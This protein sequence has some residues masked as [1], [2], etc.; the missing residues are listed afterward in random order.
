MAHGPARWAV[1]IGILVAGLAGSARADEESPP[2]GRG[3]GER[4]ASFELTDV[5]S[6]QSRD[7]ARD[8]GSK[9]TVLVFLGTDCPVGNLYL[10]R[11]NEL[12]ATYASKGV[13]LWGINANASE[14]AATVADHARKFHLSFPVL[15]DSDGHVA[16][17]LQALRT[18]EAL[19]IGADGV[20]HY[21]GAIDDQYQVGLRKDSEQTRHHLALA[22][23]AVIDG[24][25]PDTT[26]TTVDGCPIERPKDQANGRKPLD[27]VRPPSA[28]IV[29]AY[30]QIEGKD[31]PDVGDVTYARDVAP[32]LQARC[33]SCHRPGQVG[34][35]SLLTYDD[36]KRWGSG[37]HEV[38]DNRRMPPWH[39]DPRHGTFANDRHLSPSQRATLLAWVED[40]CPAGDLGQAPPNPE[41][42]DGWSIG[43]PDQVFEIP[44]PY[45]VPADGVLAY[46]RF[47]VKTHFT[48]DRWVQA[49]EAR[50][51]DRNVVHHIIVYLLDPSAADDSKKFT[52]LCGYAPGDMPSRFPDGIAKRI[53]AGAEL[54]FELHYTPNG[55]M[56]IDRS[57]VGFVFA[58]TPPEREA[59]TRGIANHKFEI[60]P[61]DANSEVHS[62]ITVRQDSVLLSFMPHMHLRG[63]DFKYTAT[64]PD[65][66]SEVL[67]SVPAYDFNWQSYYTLAEPRKMPKGTRIDCVAHFDNSSANPANPDPQATVHWGDQTFEEMMI[68]Y[69]DYVI[70]EPIAERKITDRPATTGQLLGKLL[71]KR[72]QQRAAQQAR[73]SAR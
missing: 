38:V 54:V 56:T 63:K 3:V 18:C 8:G 32:I 9:A 19:V 7:L 72:F 41:F 51:G 26:S 69:I 46:E 62:S 65:G 31:L 61:G 14:S 68:G 36:A 67:L 49:A 16:T 39:A 37:I 53:P 12:A 1:G 71:L 27:R 64:F 30:E 25:E 4:V 73:A 15:K 17:A 29:S 20:L 10:P 52:H 47:R 11:L 35:F 2:I 23:D 66:T 33:Q 57:A 40:G 45:T 22:I 21:R 5:L 60:A 28:E 34:P 59:I 6:G 48:E 42:S 70:D 58:K 44:A 43:E 24:H 13:A 55:K 50:P